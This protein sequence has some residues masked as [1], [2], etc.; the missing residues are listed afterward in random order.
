[1]ITPI[2]IGQESLP[3]L[4]TE[5]EGETVYFRMVLKQGNAGVYNAHRLLVEVLRQGVDARTHRPFRY[6]YGRVVALGGVESGDVIAGWLRQGRGR[7]TAR[8][9]M[10]ND[11]A[12]DITLPLSEQPEALTT[13]T[14]RMY[15]SQSRYGDT[16]MP[17]PYTE[18]HVLTSVRHPLPEDGFFIAPDCPFFPTFQDLVAEL[19]YGIRQNHPTYND[20]VNEGISVRIPSTEGWIEHVRLGP[21]SLS[22]TVKGT[23]VRDLRVEVSGAP[24]LR[25]TLPLQHML[26][27][28]VAKGFQEAEATVDVP[29]GIPPTLWIVVS[30]GS[31]CLDYRHLDAQ[32]S[33]FQTDREGV[34][35]E[36]PDIG[37][38]VREFVAQGEG[39]T[40]EF[41][42]EPPE[43][44]DQKERVFKTVAAF[45]NGDGGVI[46][47]GVNDETGHI[48]GVTAPARAGRSLN[49]EKDRLTDLIRQIVTPEPDARIEHCAVDGKPVILIYVRRGPTPPYGINPGKPVFYVRRGATTFPARPDEVR[50]LSYR[51]WQSDNPLSV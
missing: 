7:A 41:K 1:M 39:P 18:H 46:I 38:Q 37:A 24:Y 15:P 44:Q 20:L 25:A 47:L 21:T 8:R 29:T 42:Q 43:T 13:V 30:H 50:S 36:P 49:A 11:A 31:R 28:Y 23:S 51:S 3:A 2:A 26:S 6:D 12:Y 27:G 40:I 19:V 17:L 34:T 48:V 45:A 9:I 10:P 32:W 4:L 22:I 14:W 5:L 35:I 33:P 16:V